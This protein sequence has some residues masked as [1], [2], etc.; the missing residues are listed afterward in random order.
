VIAG[1]KYSPRTRTSRRPTP[2]TFA[3]LRRWV[4]PVERSIE[5]TTITEITNIDQQL[6]QISRF[7]ISSIIQ[8]VISQLTAVYNDGFVSLR[9]TETGHLIVQNEREA[10]TVTSAKI[11]FAASGDQTII[12]GQ[13]GLKIKITSLVFTVG[14]ETNITLK[15]DATALTGPMDFGGTNEPRG[16][17]DTQGFLP[18]EL[19]AGAAFVINSS[20]AVQVS[21]YVT[22]YIEA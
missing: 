14:G 3:H 12:A 5:L 22:G 11:D 15:G 21:G 13:V 16:I 8:R 2:E 7:Y 17:V 1:K 6:E 19:T 18:Y 20:A 4:E 9:A 10:K